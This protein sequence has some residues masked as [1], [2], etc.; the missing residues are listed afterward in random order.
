MPRVPDDD[1]AAAVLATRNDA[2]ERGVVE[3]V[4]LGHDR[5]AAFAVRVGRPVRDRPRLQHA[6]GLEAEVVVQSP[7]GVLLNDERERPGA[8]RLG[9]GAG[10]S[11]F[12]KSRLAR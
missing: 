9:P 7:R 4:V 2:F 6:V 5:K 1:L 3:R 11:V 12:E 8:R 10:S